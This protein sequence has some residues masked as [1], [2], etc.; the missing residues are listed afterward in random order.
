MLL[1]PGPPGENQVVPGYS[2]IQRPEKAGPPSQ[3]PSISPLGIA[4]VYRKCWTEVL[5]APPSQFSCDYAA[6]LAGITGET[7]RK[8]RILHHVGQRKK[9][10]QTARAFGSVKAS[11]NSEESYGLLYVPFC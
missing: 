10:V 5:S 7:A 3:C 9:N 6:S 4:P 8:N 1:P 2:T 11:G